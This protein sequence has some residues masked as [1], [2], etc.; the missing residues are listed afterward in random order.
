MILDGLE[1][2]ISCCKIIT[3]VRLLSCISSTLTRP[4][5]NENRNRKE[6]KDQSCAL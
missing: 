1:K 4:N 3:K 2:T 6:G 5:S